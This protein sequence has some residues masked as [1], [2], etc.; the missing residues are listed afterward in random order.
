MC[1][2]GDIRQLSV[3]CPTKD[4]NRNTGICVELTSSRRRPAIGF[5]CEAGSGLGF[6]FFGGVSRFEMHGRGQ[7]F[8]RLSLKNGDARSLAGG[9]SG[10]RI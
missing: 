8:V 2:S 1:S 5:L 4:A 6:A 9:I 7:S 10:H 3:R